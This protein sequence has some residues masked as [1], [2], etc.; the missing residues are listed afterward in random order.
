M[1]KHTETLYLVDGMS[2]IFRAYYA[3]R[4]LST[5]TGLATNA[6]YGFTMMLRKVLD[7]EKPGYLAVVLDSAAPT[8][9]HEAY[10]DY[11]A[12][13]GPMPDD[14]SMQMP[15]IPR[16][17][18]VFRVPIV[19]ADG[20]EA[21]DLIGTLA[22][23][24]EQKDLHVYIVTQDKDLCQL[25]TDKVTVLR[26]GRDRSV[27]RLD[28]KGVEEKL[29]VP[30]DKVVDLLGL[31]G[32]ASDNIP[33][34]P[35][36][37]EKGALQ[38]IQEFG[39]IEGALANWELVKRKTYRE[40]LRD[41][42]DLIRQ[43]RELATIKVDCPVE[44]DLDAL[45]VEAPDR[46]AAYALFRELEFGALTREF[47]DA[48]RAAPAAAPQPRTARSYTRV[49][50][51]AEVEQFVETLWTVDQFAVA[52][53]PDAAGALAGVA[54]SA[55]PGVAV[56]VDLAASDDQ[57]EAFRALV[58]VLENGLLRTY[59][60]DWKSALHR[61]N[62]H[63]EALDPKRAARVAREV[64]KC[65]GRYPWEGGVRIE[66][67]A[68][69]T[70][71]AAYLLDANRA[72][73]ALRELAREHLGMEFADEIEGFDAAQALAL[74]E[75]DAT[76]ALGDHLRAQLVARGLE[77]VYERMELPLVEVLYEME[78]TG[79]LV[80]HDALAEIGKSLDAESA[81]L[82]ARVYE[83]AGAEFNI[84]SP[85]QL[86]EVFERLNFSVSRKT[87][88]GKV[89]TSRDVLEE[90]AA[91]YELP[92]LVIE[93]RELTKLKSTYVDAIPALIDP[94]T[95]RVHT[96]LNQTVASTGRLSSSNPNLQ[97]IPVR[98]KAGRS[99]RRAFV[100]AP[101]CVLVS[102]DYS[103]IELRVLAHMT[104]DRRMTEA[105]RSGEDIHAATARAVFGASSAAE[106]KEKR[107]LAKVVNFAIAYNVGAFGLA[108]RTGLS[109]KEAK[110]AIETYYASFEG[111]RRYMEELPEQARET[112]DVRTI[113]GRVRQI[114]DI[115]NSNHNL[116][117]R[118][119]REAINMPIQGTAADLMKL[120]MIAVYRALEREG[121][122]G[123]MVMQVHD[124]LLLEVPKAKAKAV[125]ELLRREMEAVYPLDVPLVVDVG[126]GPNWMDAK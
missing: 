41:N 64:S 93:Y 62:R 48:A 126:S 18:D 110:Q 8:F 55:A 25:V 66:S 78:R 50:R 123:R 112:G 74:Q 60:H 29:G 16:V 23:Q 73:Y 125:G 27:A 22:R 5:S 40:S 84:N 102:A 24:A 43:S 70:L 26:E 104:G 63:L 57:A 36:I 69:D 2:T 101:G 45:R 58:G 114:P 89:S 61:L 20:Y 38:L 100:A 115:N 120:A 96:S 94:A 92:R 35:G 106:E 72:R 49:A 51:L 103:Q 118:A 87:A 122:P 116:R 54:V 97:N 10:A 98:T 108:Q 11:K 15:Y 28:P 39:S 21:D 86:A 19:Q 68:E 32:D 71:L 83:L 12:T 4:G 77:D 95:G 44:L 121:S 34:A 33:G 81:R 117:A 82:A 90:L 59:V 79:L 119:E 42:A 47:A 6:I 91:K 111:V 7:Q 113:F 124:E 52:L 67:A 53:A 1:S 31:Q 3:I 80:D 109:R 76:L 30:P 46:A 17:C 107:R 65:S 9:R 75:A 14:M 56:Y 88:T 105:F 99:I 85:A 37:G 13:R